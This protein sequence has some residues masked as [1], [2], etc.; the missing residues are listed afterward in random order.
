M[1]LT[2]TL[3]RF[4]GWLLSALV[5]VTAVTFA[6]NNQSPTVI[7]LWPLGLEAALPLYLV[8]IIPLILGLVVG[9]AI[10]WIPSF[11]H[12]LNAK[13]L[14]RDVERLERQLADARQD[15][16]NQKTGNDNVPA[17]DR[18]RVPMLPWA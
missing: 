14:S 5:A 17:S 7:S 8:A 4:C 18:W 6:L 10:V 15:L 9:G 16:A 2:Y 1:R 3:M 12:W 13:R 11:K